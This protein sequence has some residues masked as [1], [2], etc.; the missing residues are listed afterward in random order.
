VISGDP[1]P[2]GNMFGPEAAI[3]R[4]HMSPAYVDVRER[5]C[6][7]LAELSYEL[8]TLRP[9]VLHIAAH[10][11][12]GGL[13]LSLN[14]SARCV[15]YEAVAAII[16]RSFRPRLI[17]L[18]A[19]GSHKPSRSLTKLVGALITWPALIDDDLC[20]LFA[21]Q[22]YLSLAHGGRSLQHTLT[23]APPSTAIQFTPIQCSTEMPTP[24]PCSEL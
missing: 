24:V 5:A 18:C 9:T 22:L 13:F 21:G 11:A 19:C 16:E 14:G 10:S 4:R 1:R 23:P 12:F 20:R 17:V 8:D 15:G 7:E 3:I 2:G 6:I